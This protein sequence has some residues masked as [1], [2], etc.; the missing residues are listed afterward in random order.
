MKGKTFWK[1]Q[2]GNKY[3]IESED[4]R[5]IELFELEGTLGDHLDQ[6]PCNEQGQLQLHLVA[7]GPIQLDLEC[8]QGQGIHHLSVQDVPAPHH[9]YCKELLPYIQLE[10]LLF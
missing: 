4:Y 9:T 3:F 2:S 1:M 8:L 7:Q 10:S 5:I 6:L